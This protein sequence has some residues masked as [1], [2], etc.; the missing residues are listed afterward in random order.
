MLIY[1]GFI[2]AVLALLLLNTL[3]NLRLL[4]AQPTPLAIDASALVSILVPARNEARSIA[5]CIESLAR[6][7]YPRCE[8][9]VLDDQSEDQTAA[10]VEQLAS[11]YPNVR[12]LRGRALP[13]N[14]HG[15][16]YAC[17]QLAEAARGEWLLFVDAD[18][19]LAPQCVSVTLRWAQAQRAGLLTM[20]PTLLAKSFGEAVLL[21][22]VPLT[23][24][25]V[26]PLGL[27]MHHPSP[28]F[29]GALGQFLLFDRDTYQRIGGHAAVRMDIV[30]DMQLSRLV[31]RHG[32][33]VVWLDG[34]VLMRVRMYQSFT[35]AWH[36]IAKSAFAA[37]N[38]STPA[39]LPGVAICAALF[40][41]PYVFLAAGL[42][43]HSTASPALWL[44]LIQVTMLWIVQLLLMRR[45]HLPLSLAFFQAGTILAVISTVLYSAA[46]SNFGEGVMWKGRTYQFDVLGQSHTPSARWATVLVVVRLLIAAAL[47]WSGG[48]GAHL[49]VAA[50]LLLLGWTAAM[51]E[52]LARK[53]VM[54]QWEMWA[55]VGGG[56]A[57]LGY[58]QLSGLLSLWL[59]LLV[60]LVIA[61]CAHWL[62]WQAVTTMASV[63]PGGLLLI[64]TETQAPNKILLGWFVL[65]ALVA[66]RSLAHIVIPWLQRFRSS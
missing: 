2:T 59:A 10:I 28:V 48:T 43:N 26:L 31:K 41:G 5:R 3:H 56:L 46:Q 62:P 54:S 15:K 47:I 64:I 55:D 11:R 33:R 22:T 23:F 53:G 8:I 66:S 42:L 17:A 60:V 14:W 34:S 7:D 49:Q 4:R 21:P 16:A 13:P 29:A 50:T 27:V 6:Q 40:W 19:M 39:L 24:V 44:P 51:L 9:I 61:L 12:L 45:C 25:A 38:Y 30:E 52:F 37:I 63:L 58:L 20:V 57:C 35:E 32:G 36:G 18:V 1:Q 65:I